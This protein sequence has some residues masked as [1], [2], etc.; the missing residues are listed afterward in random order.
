MEAVKKCDSP[1]GIQ[2]VRQ[3]I[4]KCD[5]HGGDSQG[6][7]EV[8]QLSGHVPVLKEESNELGRHGN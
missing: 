2:K 5:G 1:Q 7:W 4:D 3:L 8:L 6:I